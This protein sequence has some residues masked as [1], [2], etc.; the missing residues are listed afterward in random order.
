MINTEHEARE[1]LCPIMSGTSHWNH[2]DGS[3]DESFDREECHASKCMAWRWQDNKNFNWVRLVRMCSDP[4]A[5]EEPDRGDVPED[6]EWRPFVEGDGEA[7]CWAES[8]KSMN[9]KRRGYC[10][11]VPRP[12]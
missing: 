1:K 6:Y 5:V 11:L 12:E 4:Y 7:A 2:G 8:D 9:A 3:P 10:G